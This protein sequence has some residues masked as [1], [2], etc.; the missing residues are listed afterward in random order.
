[1]LG[2]HPHE[3]P[4]LR[5]GH[6]VHI[7]PFHNDGKRLTTSGNALPTGQMDGEAGRFIGLD[8]SAV[9]AVGGQFGGNTRY[10]EPTRHRLVGSRPEPRL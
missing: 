9:T 3:F 1:L 7:E 5:S 8:W 2:Q 10:A 6:P 4:Q